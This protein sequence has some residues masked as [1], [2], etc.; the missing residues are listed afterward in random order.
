MALTIPRPPQL[1]SRYGSD[2]NKVYTIHK[3]PNTV[4]ASR[5]SN[6]NVFISVICC[7]KR[8]SA[9][10][11]AQMLEEH[12]RRT[13]DWPPLVSEENYT[14]PESTDELQ[15]LSIVSW[16]REDLEKFCTLNILDLITLTRITKE[17]GTYYF[18]G[19]LVKLTTSLEVYK[20]RFDDLYL[21]P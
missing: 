15:E 21:I 9:H 7:T 1:K 5:P 13:G 18:Q 4:Y 16:D 17:K 20:Q 19:K 8:S 12:K 3:H 2:S 6:E 14:L 10:K 11:L